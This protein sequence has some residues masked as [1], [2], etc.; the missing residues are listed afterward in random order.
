MP[1]SERQR[2]TKNW[3]LG[4]YDEKLLF[5]SKIKYFSYLQME[6]DLLW[7]SRQGYI[8]GYSRNKYG[9]NARRP[10]HSLKAKNNA[11][12]FCFVKKKNLILSGH[13]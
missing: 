12:V 11:E 5:Y 2:I 3:Q 4:V 7:V 6:K 13:T 1:Y 9:I 8:N 10:V